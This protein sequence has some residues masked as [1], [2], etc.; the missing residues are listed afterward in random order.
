MGF[1]GVKLLKR[2]LLI[3]LPLI[4][5]IC[6]AGFFD[7]SDYKFVASNNLA[8]ETPIVIVDAGHG[9]FDGGAVAKD[10]TVEKD[11]NLS[12]ANYLR[13][14]LVSNGAKVVMTRNSDMATDD[15]ETKTIATRKKSDLKNRVN[16]MKEYPDAIYVSIHLNKFTTSAANGAQV[17][18]SQNAKGSKELGESIQKSIKTKLQSYNQR[19]IK[20]GTGSTYIL[21][22]ATIPTVIAECGFISNH[23]ELEKLKDKSY[24]RKMAFCIYCGINDYYKKVIRE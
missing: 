5:M 11:I 2:K 16:L 21:K 20:K 3:V 14:F 8:K 19:V 23:Q 15:V 6:V 22:N 17:F 9:G 10:G 24:Q 18:Y 1:G 13:N 4:C 7:F 12:I